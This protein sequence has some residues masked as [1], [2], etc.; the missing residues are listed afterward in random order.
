MSDGRSD[1][2][3]R[4]DDEARAAYRRQRCLRDEVR[5]RLCDELLQ[6][7]AGTTREELLDLCGVSDAE[8]FDLLGGRRGGREPSGAA[9]EVRP[10]VGREEARAEE[11]SAETL[12]LEAMSLGGFLWLK[13]MRLLSHARVLT[14]S[15]SSSGP[16]RIEWLGSEGGWDPSAGRVLDVDDEGSAGCLLLLLRGQGAVGVREVSDGWVVTVHERGGSG[17]VSYIGEGSTL[18]RACVSAARAC[19]EW[20]GGSQGV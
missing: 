10:R 4:S 6:A 7:A 8:A 15:V 12:G 20:R 11:A 13:G 1:A 16:S 3:R 17:G 5:V 18:G 19:G 14:T 9:R 2:V